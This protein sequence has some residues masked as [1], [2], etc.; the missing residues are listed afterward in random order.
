MSSCQI[1]TDLR[2]AYVEKAIS[3]HQINMDLWRAYVRK[4]MSSCQIITDLR[5][6]YVGKGISSHQINMDLWRAYVRAVF[7]RPPAS[8]KPPSN[9]LTLKFPNYG[10]KILRQFTAKLH[11]LATAGMNK[12]QQ[13]G[14]EGLGIQIKMGLG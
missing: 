12:T 7:D 6:A 4:G 8:R 5:W 3:S 1:I 2:W 14:M 13:P 9:F 11:I 10:L